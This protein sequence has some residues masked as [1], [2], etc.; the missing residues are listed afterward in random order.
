[1]KKYIAK[2]TVI[3]AACYEFLSMFGFPI[4]ATALGYQIE[5]FEKVWIILLIG[6]VVNLVAMIIILKKFP[7]PLSKRKTDMF[8][9]GYNDFSSF[10]Q[11]LQETI[12]NRG[13]SLKEYKIVEN[14]EVFYYMR[15]R[16]HRWGEKEYIAVIKTSQLCDGE[17]KTIENILKDLLGLTYDVVHTITIVCVDCITPEFQR[18]VNMRASQYFKWSRFHAGISFE[19]NL[20]YLSNFDEKFGIC[21]F[22]RLR[23]LFLSMITNKGDITQVTV[24]CPDEN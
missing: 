17:I 24:P 14:L 8:K 18:F 2:I 19:N 9:I 7:I 13:F 12:K 11:A 23:K 3:Y 16:K 5:A 15:K 6:N 21:A 4:L 1:M 20:C 22:K 10:H